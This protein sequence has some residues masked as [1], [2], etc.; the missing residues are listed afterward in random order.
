MDRDATQVV[1]KKGYQKRF[2]A[3]PVKRH[4]SRA[5]FGGICIAAAVAQL[6]ERDC[7]SVAVAVVDVVVAVAVVDVVVVVALDVPVMPAVLGFPS[8]R[9]GLCAAPAASRPTPAA[10]WGKLPGEPGDNWA[11]P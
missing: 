8:V 3:R 11:A 7:P 1:N 2:I 5:V 9:V 4:P 10:D 6:G